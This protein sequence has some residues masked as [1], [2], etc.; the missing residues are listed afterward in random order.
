MR[1]LFLPLRSNSSWFSTTSTRDRL[2]R[3][4]KV[5]LVLYDRLI[6]QD[7]RYRI[8]AGTDGQGMDMLLP[9]NKCGDD[10]KSISFYEPGGKFGVRLGDKVLLQSESYVSYDVDF[11][12]IFYDAGLL[13]A[14]YIEWRPIDLTA[15]HQ[16][17]AD[18]QAEEDSRNDQ[19]NGILPEN[20][21][22]RGAILRAIYRDSFLAHSLRTPFCV[23]SAVAP[24]VQWKQRLG[25]TAW[26]HELPPIFF[27]CW[28]KL[29]LPDFSSYSWEEVRRVRESGAGADLRMMMDRTLAQIEDALPNISDQRE[30]SELVALGMSKELIRE[31][32]ARRS[33]AAGTVVNLALNWLPL[34]FFGGALAGTV[35]DLQSLWN[36][37]GSWL[38]LTGNRNKSTSG[39]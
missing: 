15:Q 34:P 22:L 38:S 4:I 3:Q 10:R 5:N 2:E 27:D 29:D 6:V 35:K 31:V 26:L 37:R 8:T 7:G 28:V 12:P 32:D 14:E 1:E 16:R 24:V 25:K 21:Y 13:D 17:E 23:D 18:Q 36:E 20:S 11:Y 30:I 39:E 33:R 19:L 9:T